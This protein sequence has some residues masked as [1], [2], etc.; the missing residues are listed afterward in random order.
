MIRNLIFV[1]TLIKKIDICLNHDINLIFVLTLIRNLI[2]VLTLITKFDICPK[3]DKKFD[4][5]P[6]VNKK[7]D[8]C[9]NFDN[10]FDICQPWTEMGT[11]LSKLERH[12]I[13]VHHEKKF[14]ICPNFI[15]VRKC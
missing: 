3:V 1:L 2:Y 5:C 7:F 12:L 4:I 14:D 6:N 8:I 13:F 15:S 9:P 11:Y 10:K